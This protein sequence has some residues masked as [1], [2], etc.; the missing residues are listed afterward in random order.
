MIGAMEYAGQRLFDRHEG[1]VCFTIETPH[2]HDGYG[3]P[4]SIRSLYAYGE[5]LGRALARL[6]VAGT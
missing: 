6:V 1:H 4:I 3:T 5:A 2:W